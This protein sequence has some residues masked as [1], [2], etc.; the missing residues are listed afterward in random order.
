MR[1]L[2]AN[3]PARQLPDTWSEIPDS[4]RATLEG[5]QIRSASDWLRLSRKARASIFGIPPGIR[6]MLDATARS[7]SP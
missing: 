1:T 6:R 3:P 7:A 5:E 4:I 2:H